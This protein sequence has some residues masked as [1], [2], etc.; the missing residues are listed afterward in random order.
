MTKED[1]IK[2][3]KELAKVNEVEEIDASLIDMPEEVEA[4]APKPIEEARMSDEEIAHFELIREQKKARFAQLA[5][6]VEEGAETPAAAPVKRSKMV[7]ESAAPKKNKFKMSS[8]S[9]GLRKE[10]AA[11]VKEGKTKVSQFPA[12]V[13][14]KVLKEMSM[15]P[16]A[17]DG[18]A[19][20]ATAAHPGYPE[21]DPL[22]D[23]MSLSVR[24]VILKMMDAHGFT[25]FGDRNDPNSGDAEMP[26]KAD[27][28]M[29]GIINKLSNEA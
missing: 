16:M 2:R 27:Y 11:L 7:L 3:F 9:E 4:E 6:L 5:G 17:E 12:D 26:F 14:A 21:L 24:N 22:I 25:E 18:M 13:K 20:S 23:T 29:K 8:L 28:I 1:K 10:V 15:M 19:A